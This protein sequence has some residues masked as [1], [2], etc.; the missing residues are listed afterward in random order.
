MPSLLKTIKFV[1]RHPYNSGARI[2]AICRFALWQIKCR[3]SAQPHL[4]RL[5][6]KTNLWLRRGAPTA[7][8][9]LYCGLVEWYE[10]WFVLH[11]LRP[12]DYFADVG[13]NI[14]VY[15]LLASGQSGAYTFAIEPAAAA[16]KQL[17]ENINLNQLH[18]LVTIIPAAMGSNS[19]QLSLTQHLGNYNHV[20]LPGE[21]NIESVEVLT[22]DDAVQAHCP[23]L[24][25]IDVEGYETEVLRGA[26][27]TL[28]NPELQ[29][30]VIELNGS[31]QRYGFSD[32]TIHDHLLSL[33]FAPY[34]YEP[35]TRELIALPAFGTHNTIYLR[36]QQW[37]Q[38]RIWSAPKVRVGRICW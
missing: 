12:G 37:V 27:A 4:Y 36:N 33:G 20:A 21:P 35:Q 38:Q 7:T 30:V 19:G 29:A 15:T 23:L 32:E 25:K 13:A 28:S 8:G 5:T 11:L 16:R 6:E 17:E 10:M 1:W 31:G 22:L 26:G 24:I 9:C 18:H 3:L 14:G 34:H 2:P